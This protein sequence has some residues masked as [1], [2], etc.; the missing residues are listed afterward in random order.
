MSLFVLAFQLSICL[1]GGPSLPAQH[2]FREPVALVLIS[3]QGGWESA[4]F[5]LWS[6]FHTH[7]YTPGFAGGKKENGCHMLPHI[8]FKCKKKHIHTLHYITLSK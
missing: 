3:A 4:G 7:V 6:N 1:W 5:R 2:P 8:C